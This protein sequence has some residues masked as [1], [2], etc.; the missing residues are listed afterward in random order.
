[1]RHRFGSACAV[2]AVRA[3]LGRLRRANQKTEVAALLRL[4]DLVAVEAAVA[5]LRAD[6]VRRRP[7]R[8]P[9]SQLRFSKNKIKPPPA[10]AQA[11]AVA[12]PHERER[13][14]DGRLR[15]DMEHDRAERGAAHA[16]VGDA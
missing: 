15:R 16:R 1:M 8:A 10:H 14:A 12:G 5:A 7:G 2:W 4:K 13:S 11:D 3:E 6:A 9:L